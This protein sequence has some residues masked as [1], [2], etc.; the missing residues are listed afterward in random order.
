MFKGLTQEP[1][2]A[3]GPH[4]TFLRSKCSL[5]SSSVIQLNRAEGKQVLEATAA[6]CTGSDVS[7]LGPVSTFLPSMPSKEHLK[8]HG[9]G[10]YRQRGVSGGR[11]WQEIQMRRGLVPPLFS[12]DEIMQLP[13]RWVSVKT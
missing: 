7:F 6:R 9:T 10:V 13:T 2:C 8:Q 3:D 1:T 11:K 5:W 4:V 12:G